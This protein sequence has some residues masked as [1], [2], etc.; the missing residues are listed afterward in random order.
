MFASATSLTIRFGSFIKARAA[1]TSPSLN[2]DGRP[3]LRPRLRASSAGARPRCVRGSATARTGRWRRT[4]VEDEDPAGRGRVDGLGQRHEA[5]PPRF[6]RS[7]AVVMSFLPR[8]PSQSVQFPDDEGVASDRSTSSSTRR[9]SGRS[10]RAPEALLGEDLPATGLGQRLELELGVLINR[11]DPGVAN[12]H[13]AAL[14]K[15]V[16]SVAV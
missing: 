16:R 5:N 13:P 3:P 12:P 2:A 1:M 8:R 14:S 15:A 10:S 7:S 11:A 6:S 4:C 9:N